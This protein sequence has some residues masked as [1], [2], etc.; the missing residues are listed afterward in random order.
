MVKVT[1][2]LDDATVQRIRRI[3][4][5]L[6]NPQSQVV[7]EAVADFAARADRLSEIERLRMLKVIE[8]IREAPPTRSREE[9]KAE[10]REIHASRRMGWRRHSD[11][12]RAGPKDEQAHSSSE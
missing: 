12:R 10:L 11:P 6:G 1:H 3:A 2:S 7:R 9:T 8:G 4:E 5:Q